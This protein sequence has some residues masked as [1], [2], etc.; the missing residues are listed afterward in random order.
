MAF[1]L[2]ASLVLLP[3]TGHAQSKADIRIYL[4]GQRIESDVAPYIKPKVNLTMVPVRVVS[5]G[6]G[7]DVDWA[8]KTRTVTVARAGVT[9]VMQVGQQSATVGGRSVT[10]DA[11]PEITQGRVMVPLR[12]IGESLGL[13]VAWNADNRWIQ[14]SS[15]PGQEI[16]GVWI[17]TVFN[18]DWPQTSSYGQPE[19]QKQEYAA[20]LDEL[21][22]MGINAVF[23]QV[24]TAGDALYPTKLAPWSKVLTGKQGQDPGYDPLAYMIEETHRRGMEF[25]AWFNPF[26]AYTSAASRAELADG[27]AAVQHPEWVVE[28]GG[29]GYFNPGIP[30]VRQH[31]IEAIAEVAKRYS[32]DGIHLDDYF[33]PTDGKFGDDAAFGAYNP[34]SIASKGDW[35]RANINDFVR[36]LG[37][38]VHAAKPGLAYGIS[39]FGVWRNQADDPAGSATRASVTA[40][41]DMYADVR[42][43]IRSGWID[44]VMPQIYWSMSFP[45]AKYDTLVDWW[46]SQVDGTGVKLYIGHAPYK[47]GTKE[48]GWQSADEIV[49]Q[50]KYNET[51]PQVRG[52]VFFSAKDLRRN[53]LNVADALRAYYRR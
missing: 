20:L 39:P 6:L 27:H 30:A 41:D 1:V 50:L 36:K 14:L 51:R 34:Q 21:Q 29:V 5:Q 25:H 43:W 48:T 15:K 32:V 7:A 17:S 10:L 4:D 37:E 31:I 18:L 46:A 40:Y 2:A 22:L 19:K 24:R 26:R 44:Y 52:D 12:F 47:L 13:Q 38:A 35:R 16:R 11:P 8:Q 28:A 53:P 23:V 33:Y 3:T 49:N 42:T 45:A 9:I